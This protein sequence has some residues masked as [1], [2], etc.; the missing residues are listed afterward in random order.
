M[1]AGIVN[2]LSLN[3]DAVMLIKLTVPVGYTVN[4]IEKFKKNII[5]S[6]VFLRVR[7]ALYCNFHSFRIDLGEHSE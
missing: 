7:K 1:E 4:V 6:P 2:V 3:L 5:F